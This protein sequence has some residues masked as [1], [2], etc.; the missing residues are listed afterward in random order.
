[1]TRQQI[2]LYTPELRDEAPALP[3]ATVVRL[4]LAFVA[5]LLLWTGVSVVSVRVGRDAATEL[6]ASLSVR[7]ERLASLELE[8]ARRADGA[9]L[10]ARVAALQGEVSRRREL[11]LAL[12]QRVGHASQGFAAMLAGLGR[13]RVEGVWLTGFEIGEGGDTLSLRGHTVSGPLVVRYL[14][15]LGAE[16]PFSG[17]EF[18]TFAL[19]RDPTQLRVATF[20]VRTERAE[21]S[22]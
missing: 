2:N 5:V 11:A 20:D 18:R 19:E 7:R 3:T 16:P 1:M 21:A 6:E 14:A 13:Q 22:P 9:E 10:D 8:V 17:R 4:V 12:A 15:R